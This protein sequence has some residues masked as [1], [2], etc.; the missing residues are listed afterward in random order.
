MEGRKLNC[1]YHFK[2]DYCFNFFFN[3]LSKEAHLSLLVFLP[4]RDNSRTHTQNLYLDMWN[5]QKASNNYWLHAS[6]LIWK[7]S[8]LLTLTKTVSSEKYSSLEE[9]QNNVILFIFVHLCFTVT[10]YNCLKMLVFGECLKLGKHFWLSG[11]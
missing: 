6:C 7:Q 4:W 5:V 2:I 8:L 11:K 3:L 9:K 1:L 10:K